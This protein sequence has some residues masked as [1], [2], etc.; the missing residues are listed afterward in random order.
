VIVAAEPTEIVTIL[1][2]C[3]AVCA[4]DAPRGIGGAN[5]FLLP[6]RAGTSPRFGNVATHELVE[7]LLWLGCRRDDL[8]AKLVGGACVMDA[9]RGRPEHLGAQNIAAARR[10]L[11][12]EGV[13]VVGSDVGG[14]RGRRL[15]F[16][17]A[18]GLCRVRLI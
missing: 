14:A 6:Y 2:S 1:G 18:S 15:S 3:V 8:R 10:A 7:R 9:F 4:W 16:Q 5:H 13:H 12:D 17:T 11:A